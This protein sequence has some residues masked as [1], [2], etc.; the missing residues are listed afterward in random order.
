MTFLTLF[1]VEDANKYVAISDASS[2]LLDW[3][4]VIY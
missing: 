2:S 1:I 3:Y 4:F